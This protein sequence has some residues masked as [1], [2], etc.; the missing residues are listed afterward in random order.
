M[1][2]SPRNIA[3]G[4]IALDMIGMLWY[5][6]STVRWYRGTRETADDIKKV[7]IRLGGAIFVGMVI[8]TICQ[9]ILRHKP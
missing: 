8:L 9:L 2:V 6:V 3:L 7:N 1:I 5:A 4:V